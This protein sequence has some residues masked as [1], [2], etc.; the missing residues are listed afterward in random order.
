M[1]AA[2]KANE[3]VNM[4]YGCNAKTQKEAIQQA[5]KAVF[6]TLCQK[7]DS[8]YIHAIQEGDHDDNYIY[9]SIK[10]LKYWQ[11]VAAELF[12]LQRALP[13]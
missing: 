13:I 6:G 5:Q 8:L 10:E 7:V 12:E 1:T 9:P 3:L 4:Y 2:Q 11:E